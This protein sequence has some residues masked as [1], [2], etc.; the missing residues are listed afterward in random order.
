MDTREPAVY[1]A[2]YSLSLDIFRFVSTCD[3]PALKVSLAR[4]LQDKTLDLLTG[5][6]QINNSEDKLK[7]I[8]KSINDLF[9]LKMLLRLFLDLN[10]MKIEINV[11]LLEKLSGVSKQL[12]AWK[13]SCQ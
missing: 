8:L 7:A 6:Y 12:N 2:I 5:I 11:V 13:G 9:S 3:T 10:L 1:R 4:S